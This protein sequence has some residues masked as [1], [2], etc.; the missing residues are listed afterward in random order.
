[1]RIH[2]ITSQ[3]V[4]NFYHI[5]MPIKS[6]EEFNNK[7]GIDNK[8]KS[9]IRI[10]DIGKDISPTPIEIVMR[11]QKPETIHGPNFNFIVNLHATNGKHCVLV[12]KREGCPIHYF[13][14]FGVESPIIFLEEYVDLGSDEKIL[15]Y[16]ESYCGA[17]CLCMIYLID[18]GF[19]IKIALY[20]LINQ[21]KCPG[22]Y[23][24]C[25]CLGCCKIKGKVEDKVEDKD[26]VDENDNVNVS[27][28]MSMSVFMTMLMTMSMT[29]LMTMSMTLSMSML[30]RMLM[31]MSMLRSVSLSMTMSMTVLMI[32]KEPASQMLMTMTTLIREPTPSV[33]CQPAPLISEP[34]LQMTL[35]VKTK[36][37]SI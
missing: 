15:E 1:M 23:N 30:T 6:I 5:K 12:I 11:D 20:N 33:A 7:F 34:V 24:E 27:M 36:L 37:I 28:T 4:S 10:E 31:T 2:I 26:I 29:I 14:I 3:P 8:A 16:A 22:M 17:H 18:K 13:D 35:I 21:I 25:L 19:R 32:I 9:N